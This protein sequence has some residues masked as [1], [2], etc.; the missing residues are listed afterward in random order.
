MNS[1]DQ[2][3]ITKNLTVLQKELQDD[4]DIITD[5]LYKQ[6]VFTRE[7]WQDICD[8]RCRLQK[9]NC[10]SF[11]NHLLRS[12]KDSYAKFKN[13]LI[14]LGHHKLVTAL[15]KASKNENELK[16]TEDR[17]KTFVIQDFKHP[18]R[19][20]KQAWAEESNEN[21]NQAADDKI[22]N[23]HLERLET[24]A[25]EKWDCKDKNNN[26]VNLGKEFKKVFKEESFE[27]EELTKLFKTTRFN[28]LPVTAEGRAY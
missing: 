11:I 8:T 27:D 9:S 3:K 28:K 13:I 10:S 17:G 7:V 14:D 20:R 15:E 26:T 18:E 16:W 21:K 6:K 19:I 25:T 23:I 1:I 12:G 22:E 2:K 4:V 5:K 24:F